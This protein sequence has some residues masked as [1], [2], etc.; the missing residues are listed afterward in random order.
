MI[1]ATVVATWLSCDSYTHP[2][3]GDLT[4]C[5][6]SLP[7]TGHCREGDQQ[8]AG[9]CVVQEEGLCGGQSHCRL[10]T[11]CTRTLDA[12]FPSPPLPS[13]SLST[14]SLPSPP[15]DVKDH[16][17]AH[18][19]M[20]DSQTLIKVDQAHLET[21]LPALGVCVCIPV[22]TQLYVEVEVT[23]SLSSRTLPSL[24]ISLLSLPS[25]PSPL[26]PL[27]P[28]IFPSPSSPS[29]P[30]PSLFLPPYSMYLQDGRCWW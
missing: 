10:L 16:Y 17:T 29:P 8:T 22:C 28:P 24:L 18:V 14:P 11:H 30:L 26:L 27:H 9:G 20:L 12:S 4:L 25:L 6:L 21:V 19:R 13:P 3:C 7:W 15:Q 2:S 23:T 1:I 5:V